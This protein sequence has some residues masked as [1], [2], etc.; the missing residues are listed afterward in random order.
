MTDSS[1]PQRMARNL[2][3]C[4]SYGTYQ[5]GVTGGSGGV[6]ILTWNGRLILKNNFESD[7]RAVGASI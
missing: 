6:A 7:Y 5:D 4:Q 2:G 3:T 1:T